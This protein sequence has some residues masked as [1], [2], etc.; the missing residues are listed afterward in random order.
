MGAMVVSTAAAAAAAVAEDVVEDVA[1]VISHT[2]ARNPHKFLSLVRLLTRP[3]YDRA[4]R[5]PKLDTNQ[6]S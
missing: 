4:L 6:H 5:L 3:D 2:N 1:V